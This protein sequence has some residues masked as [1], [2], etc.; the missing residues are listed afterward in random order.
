MCRSGPVHTAEEGGEIRGVPSAC[1]CIQKL[2]LLLLIIPAMPGYFGGTGDDGYTGLLGDRRVPKSDPR[3]EAYGALDEAS[4]ALGL[5]RA[6]ITS[7]DV[8][9]VLIEAQ[10]DLYHI[11]SE[12]AAEPEIAE[13]FRVIDRE[14]VDWLEAQIE[15]FGADVEMP[16]EFVLGGDTGPAAALD[17]ARTVVRRSERAVVRLE[18]KAREEDSTEPRTEFENPH[19]FAY[20]NRLSSLCFVLTLW[21]V[22]HQGDASPTLAKG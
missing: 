13:R 4:A 12:V 15:S 1:S 5:A 8:Q 16:K 17:Y 7:E 10:R 11:M 3:P 14:R 21:E 18:L 22:Q 19:L 2:Q 9:S 6:Q 20:L